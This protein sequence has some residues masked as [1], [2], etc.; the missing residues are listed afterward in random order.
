MQTLPDAKLE[1]MPFDGARFFNAVKGWPHDIAMK[2][3]IYLWH[4]WDATHCTG[5]VND[6]EILRDMSNCTEHNWIRV[7]A[8]IFDGQHFFYLDGGKWHQKRCRA[9][10]LR[11][12]ERYEKNLAKT[13]PARNQALVT[14]TVTDNVRDVEWLATLSANPTF[15][16]I[17]IHRELGKLAAWCNVNSK[18]VT[19]RRFINW[20]NRAERPIAASGQRTILKSTPPP[21]LNGKPQDSETLKR[22]AAQVAQQRSKL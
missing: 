9:F 14:R 10:Y 7:R 2:Y 19:R 16:G 22:M 21:Q 3:L 4:Y 6:D 15:V 12:L 17:D 8:L 1:H 20:L 18:Q 11:E 13:E 5:L